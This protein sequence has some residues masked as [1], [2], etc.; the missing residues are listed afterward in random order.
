MTLLRELL[1]QCD[2]ALLRSAVPELAV[3]QCVSEIASVLF[4]DLRSGFPR[5]KLRDFGIGALAIE[6]LDEFPLFGRKTIEISGAAHIGHYYRLALLFLEFSDEFGVHPGQALDA[7][8]MDWQF[9][10]GRIEGFRQ[11]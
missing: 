6:H 3:I 10:E 9:G 11:I 1:H 4:A 7:R 5:E 8:L 2:V